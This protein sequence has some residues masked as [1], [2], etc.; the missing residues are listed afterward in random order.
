MKNLF[1]S[2]KSVIEKI[3]ELVKDAKKKIYNKGDFKLEN[4]MKDLEE[5]ENNDQQ[6]PIAW[7]IYP[8]S[9]IQT[10]FGDTEFQ[11]TYGIPHLGIQIKSLQGNPIY[12][13]RDGVVN[14]VADN[15]DI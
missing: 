9:N 8:I 14:F 15:D 6:H 4:K 5:L 2:N 11:K 7:P 3:E 10:Y 12:A 13:A 1:E